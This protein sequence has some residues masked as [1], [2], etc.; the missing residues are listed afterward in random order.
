M[1]MP[2]QHS[3]CP[4]KRLDVVERW[5]G[6]D[7]VLYDSRSA[8]LHMLNH[9]AAAVWHLCDGRNTL[10]Q[11]GAHLSAQFQMGEGFE[12]LEDVRSILQTFAT[13][14][15][16]VEPDPVEGSGREAA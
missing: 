14:H 5:V 1:S 2:I 3:Q 10:P 11:I 13:A 7:L 12:P 4:L 16:L 9:T 15:L 6:D 8:S